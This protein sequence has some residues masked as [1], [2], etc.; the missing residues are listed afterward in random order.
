MRP[1]R[2]SIKKVD[3]TKHLFNRATQSKKFP[4]KQTPISSVVTGTKSFHTALDKLVVDN[5]KLRSKFKGL[6][7]IR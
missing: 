6:K 3:V 4:V 1:T 5:E 7:P 2:S